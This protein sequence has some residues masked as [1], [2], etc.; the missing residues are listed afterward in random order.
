MLPH[1]LLLLA[2]ASWGVSFVVIKAAVAETPPAAF[3]FWRFALAATVLFAYLGV[4]G[5]SPPRGAWAGGALMG[6]LL[7]GGYALQ[8]FGLRWTGVSNSG[9]LTG[10]YVVFTP[11]CAWLLWR[12]RIS[13]WT[14]GCAATAAVGLALMAGRSA[15]EARAGDL[16]TIG[17]AVVFA[18]HFLATERYAPRHDAAALN[19]V[20]FLVA[21]V[22]FGLGAAAFDRPALPS[23]ATAGAVVYTALVCTVFGFGCQTWAQARIPATHTALAVSL[24][25]PFA[26]L[27]G[28][29]LL[30]ERM[31]ST[32]VVGS[33]L[34]FA[35]FVAIATRPGASPPVG[36]GSKQ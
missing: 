35:A 30:G 22:V 24:E 36:V 33:V 12:R 25:A 3:L 8:T 29:L 32:G 23:Q 7:A 18:L 11:L 31:G 20:Q 26:A 21:A 15:G 9:F 6:V 14:L 27:S 13:W 34:M 4:R 10:L 17:C 5:R 16:L 1:A 28:R 19:A 2:T